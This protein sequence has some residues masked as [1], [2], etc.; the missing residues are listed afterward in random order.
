MKS[1]KAK[2][3]N[4]GMALIKAAGRE[5]FN[6]IVEL[7][8]TKKGP[9]SMKR[10]Q[11]EGL[12][13]MSQLVEVRRN[14]SMVSERVAGLAGCGPAQILMQRR[15]GRQRL[16]FVWRLRRPEKFLAYSKANPSRTR[17]QCPWF[18]A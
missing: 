2:D 7:L 6:E 11:Q 9:M 8:I 16:G 13:Y 4:G 17:R 10:L 3:S 12:L 1:G 5:G 14:K 15:M 18:F